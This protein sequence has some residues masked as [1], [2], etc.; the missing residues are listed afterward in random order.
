[1]HPLGI[2]PLAVMGVGKVQ[3]TV[4]G[5]ARYYLHENKW[6]GYGWQWH[7]YSDYTDPVRLPGWLSD[8]ASNYIT[9]VSNS[10]LMHDYMNDDGHRNIGA[11]ID[12]AA[13]QAGR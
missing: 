11:W 4:L 7:R 13:Q 9:P 1:V 5:A 2:N 6:D 12:R 3:E 10:A 8:P